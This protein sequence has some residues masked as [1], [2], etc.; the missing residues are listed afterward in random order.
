M[1]IEEGY[2]PFKGYK[3]TIELL[4]KRPLGKLPY[5]WFTVPRLFSQLFWITWWLRQH[6]PPA[7][8]VWSSWLWKNLLFQEDEYHLR[9]GNLGPKNNCPRENT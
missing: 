9:E 5:C 1:K 4:V 6:R 3:L 7:D 8:Y 2:M